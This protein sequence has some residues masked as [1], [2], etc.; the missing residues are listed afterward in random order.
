MTVR[1]NLDDFIREADRMSGAVVQAWAE[2]AV[3]IA[4]RSYEK[5]VEKTESSGSVD[6]GA[7]RAEHVIEQQGRPIFT[8]PD[9]VGPNVP[10]PSQKAVGQPPLIDAASI[11][12]V[13]EALAARLDPGSITF[14][15][16]RFYAELLEH[17]S[18]LI[19]ERKIYE[20]AAD[21]TEVIA[22]EVADAIS[23][24]GLR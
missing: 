15:N 16:R 13:E 6:T 19:E 5:L 23:A 14:V 11:L 20:T 10:L 3:E 2:G 21:A 24:R 8:H 9:R 17:G 7:Y 4:T 1:H 22:K 18:A 12:D